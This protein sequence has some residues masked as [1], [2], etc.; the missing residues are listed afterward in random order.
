M[1]NC[2]ICGNVADSEEHKFKASDLKRFH[3]KKMDAYYVSGEAIK[4]DSYK[5]KVLKFPKVICI[6]C[7]NTLTGPHDDAYD[8]FVDFCFRNSSE[9]KK[10]EL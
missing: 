10:A 6:N 8:K 4:I 1:K 2:W 9:I 7:N 3:G 5:D